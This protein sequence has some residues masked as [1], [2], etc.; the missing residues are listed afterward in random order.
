[1]SQVNEDFFIQIIDL[2]DV[3]RFFIENLNYTSLFHL[4]SFPGV[5]FVQDS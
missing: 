5:F 2:K 3:Y 4:D 1:M